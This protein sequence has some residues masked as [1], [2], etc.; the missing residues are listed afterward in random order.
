MKP[1]QGSPVSVTMQEAFGCAVENR[2]FQLQDDDCDP[3][4]LLH[5][6]SVESG[7][8]KKKDAASA[9][10]TGNQKGNKKESQK[11]RK[12]I[13]STTEVP[14]METKQTGPKNAPKPTLQK[15]I[16]N[17]NTGAEVKVDRTERR[18]AFREFRP[19]II[20]KPMEYSIDKYVKPVDSFEK[21]KQVRSWVAN[22]R[23]GLRGRGRG[24]FPRNMENDNQR[25]KREFDRHSGSDRARVKA[26][27]KRGGG[28]PHNWGSIKDAFS[29]EEPVP[30]ETVAEPLETEEEQDA[31]IPEEGTEDYVQEMTLDE[32]KSMMDQSRP[33]TDFNLRKPE[34]SVPSKAVVIHKSK[35]DYNIKDDDYQYGLRKPVNDITSQL[36]INFGN[37]ARPSR[38]A[39]G[40]G[41]GRVRRE[42]VLPHEVLNVQDFALNPDDP[43]DFPALC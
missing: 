19:N 34:S 1:V 21:E 14:V 7:Q 22:Q 36:D 25:G 30:V 12:T 37:L 40:G 10:K 17:E 20:E 18:T 6:A 26:E 43:D 32:W 41:R 27:D 35:F 38:G 8:R 11:E 9:K 15:V 28:G 4:D 39:R 31:K 13:V 2:F 3:L 5:Q 33:K 16:Q 29:E 42:E 24:G 23:G